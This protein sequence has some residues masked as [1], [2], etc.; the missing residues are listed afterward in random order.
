M[1][2]GIAAGNVLLSSSFLVS[3]STYRKV[4]CLADILKLTF[5]SEGTFYNIQNKYLF[6][7]V[8]EFWHQEQ[9]SVFSKLGEKD[10]WL[11]GDGCC[12]S[13]YTRIDQK[14]DKIVDFHIV[15]VT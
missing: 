3:S 12:D 14:S 6:P 5:F 13:T 8:N 1:I 7:V 2:E 10:L 9:N 4:A 15:Q 11:S